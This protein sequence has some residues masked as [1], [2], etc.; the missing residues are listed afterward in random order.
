LFYLHWP[1]FDVIELGVWPW[2]DQSLCFII[3]FIILIIRHCLS[4]AWV[5]PSRKYSTL[6]GPGGYF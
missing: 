2:F 3:K 4:L 1:S 6:K 5:V